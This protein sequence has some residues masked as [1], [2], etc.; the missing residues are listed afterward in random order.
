MVLIVS[1]CGRVFF[2]FL[3]VSVPKWK[4]LA[5]S[6]S[7]RSKNRYQAENVCAEGKARRRKAGGSV[8]SQDGKLLF[9]P[10]HFVWYCI[11]RINILICANNEV[12]LGKDFRPNQ[13]HHSVKHDSRKEEMVQAGKMKP[14]YRRLYTLIYCSVT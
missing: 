11:R 7:T 9:R 12:K 10:L 14:R 2:L 1:A 8:L 4:T 3:F 6:A 13:I 5:H